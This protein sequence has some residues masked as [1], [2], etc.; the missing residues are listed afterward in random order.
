M[1]RSLT[2]SCGRIAVVISEGFHIEPCCGDMHAHE[3]HVLH[4]VH[5]E[6]PHYEPKAPPSTG[7]F[8][9][10]TGRSSGD[11]LARVW[12]VRSCCSKTMVGNCAPTLDSPILRGER[13][14]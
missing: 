10:S 2:W 13:G 1:A 6:R 12:A 4:M 5:N 9:S 11:V 14:K 8:R 7:R 3:R